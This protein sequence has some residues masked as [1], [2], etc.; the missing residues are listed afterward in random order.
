MKGIILPSYRHRPNRLVFHFSFRHHDANDTIRGHVAATTT[1][2]GVTDASNSRCEIPETQDRDP[3]EQ[4]HKTKRW[5]F[6][7]AAHQ[8]HG[9]AQPSPRHTCVTHGTISRRIHHLLEW[10]ITAAI[11]IWRG[12]CHPC[13]HVLPAET[14]VKA[15]GC[16]ERRRQS[17]LS[18]YLSPN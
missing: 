9:T 15:L 12:F 10:Q 3:S 4:F 5:K 13:I 16:G 8:T 7:P 2:T 18:R 11:N 1:I 17:S 14:D 6:S